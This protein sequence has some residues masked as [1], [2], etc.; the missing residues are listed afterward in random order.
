MSLPSLP[1]NS[2]AGEVELATPD[3][4]ITHAIEFYEHKLDVIRYW[5]LLDSEGRNVQG[6]LEGI[7]LE[8]DVGGWLICSL[9]TRMTQGLEFGSFS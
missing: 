6:R 1:A 4:R 5:K 2:N 7:S 8:A 3:G 9:F